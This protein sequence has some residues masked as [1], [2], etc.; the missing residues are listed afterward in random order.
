LTSFLAYFGREAKLPAD[1]VLRLPDTEYASVPA[2]VKAIVERYHAVFDAIQQKKERTI[3]RS[4]AAYKKTATYVV[5]DI[6]W[7]LASRLVP[8]KT[9]EIT[10]RW[11]GPWEGVRCAT[12][13]HYVIRPAS[14]T[15]KIAEVTAHIGR[16][17]RYTRD[18][19]AN[20]IPA[21]IQ[22][23]I[24]GDKEAID[25]P[26]GNVSQPPWTSGQ[27]SVYQPET[28][29]PAERPPLAAPS[30]RDR[31]KEELSRPLRRERGAPPPAPPILAPPA[32]AVWDPDAEVEP[33]PPAAEPSATV[34]THNNTTEIE[35]TTED[36]LTEICSLQ[37]LAHSY[38]LGPRRLPT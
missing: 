6:V 32:D 36:E 26:I 17:R 18:V 23:N 20:H 3:L 30:C 14:P 5:G 28:E 35:T 16:L 13:V 34:T 2:N 7:Y 11:T 29:A 25:L 21:D 31:A 15:A 33:P 1:L 24:D 19:K 10:K 22:D 12:D 8:G 4:A 37:M 9:G 38:G 27:F